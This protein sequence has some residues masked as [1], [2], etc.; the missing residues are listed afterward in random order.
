MYG[1]RQSDFDRA[2]RTVEGKFA[3]DEK[4]IQVVF[5]NNAR[6][7]QHANGNGQIE[8][9]TFLADIRGSEVDDG[10]EPRQ[11]QA[12][13]FQGSLGALL[14]FAH[15]TVGKTYDVVPGFIGGGTQRAAGV[16]FN[17]DG[18]GVDA[19]HGAGKGFHKHSRSGR[20]NK[21]DRGR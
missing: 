21:T 20:V 17:G 14:A 2:Q 4:F 11:A 3:H 9:R 7:G 12:G 10:F 19:M 16:H 1:D 6:A 13:V 5:R 8:R 18:F 15:G